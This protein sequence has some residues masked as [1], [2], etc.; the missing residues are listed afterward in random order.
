MAEICPKTISLRNFEIPPKI[1]ILVIYL[2]KKIASVKKA[3]KQVPTVWTFN[4]R[5]FP[6]PI[7]LSKNV[8]YVNFSIPLCAKGH[9]SQGFICHVEIRFCGHVPN[10]YRNKNLESID[11]Y[12][13]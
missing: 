12:L 5:I 4:T 11:P 2:F 6:M 7:V 10:S 9:F 1:E 13:F 3:L 8:L